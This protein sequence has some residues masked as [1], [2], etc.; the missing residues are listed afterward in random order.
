MPVEQDV[1]VV[2]PDVSTMERMVRDSQRA[3][4]R[5]LNIDRRKVK[6]IIEQVE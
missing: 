4:A 6:R 2:A 1:L 3:M 5:Y